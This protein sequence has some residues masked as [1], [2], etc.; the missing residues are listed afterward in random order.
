ME[1]LFLFMDHF[2]ADTALGGVAVAL[3]SVRHS[4]RS[5]NYFFAVRAL[6]ISNNWLVCFTIHYFFLATKYILA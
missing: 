5:R 2:I 3:N 1:F 4:L 6:E